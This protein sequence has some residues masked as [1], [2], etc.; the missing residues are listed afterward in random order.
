MAYRVFVNSTPV[1]PQHPT[2]EIA[3]A[4]L[5]PSLTAGERSG[6][7]AG[8]FDTVTVRAVPLASLAR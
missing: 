1:G 8:A 3:R 5:L 6:I 4:Q 2:R 7:F